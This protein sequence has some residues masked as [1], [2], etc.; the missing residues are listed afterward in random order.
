[1]HLNSIEATAK[2]MA[3]VDALIFVA[4]C[5]EFGPEEEYIILLE[6]TELKSGFSCMFSSCYTFMN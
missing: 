3:L 1:M 2:K 6:W 5:T 4:H